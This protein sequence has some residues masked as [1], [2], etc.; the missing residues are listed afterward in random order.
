MTG[1]MIDASE[2]ARIGVV[3]RVLPKGELLAAT[4]A[5]LKT[6][7]ARGPLAIAKV[8]EVIHRGAQRP[9]DDANQL[10]QQGFASLFDTQDQKEGMAAFM[11]KRA[12]GFK[13]E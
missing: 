11:T 8:K 4:L 9:L 13:G 5:T 2:A 6:I 12:P 3:N 1:E 10:E 7:G